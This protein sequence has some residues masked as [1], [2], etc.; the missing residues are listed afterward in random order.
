MRRVWILAALAVLAG[1]GSGDGR[2]A[3]APAP[4][5][6]ADVQ[7]TQKTEYYEITGSTEADLRYQMNQK[8]IPWNDGRTYDAL[9]S[10]QIN[11]TYSYDCGKASCSIGSFN[12]EVQIVFRY[13][14]W[15]QPPDASPSLISKWN[16][17][18]H[19][20]TIHEN[21]HRDL[22]VTAASEMT[23]AAR[24]LPSAPGLDDLQKSLRTVTDV[25]MAQL[26][27]DEINYDL[28]TSHGALQGALFP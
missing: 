1:C 3:I 23:R 20:L 12:T 19:N 14:K 9:T 5:Q 26:N 22:A 24:V 7:V 13:P 21:G 6:D 28:I 16:V 4:V 2:Q 10:W 8:G 11:W 15:V 25:R 17:Y 27:A 18:M